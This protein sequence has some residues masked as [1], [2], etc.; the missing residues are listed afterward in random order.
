MSESTPPPQS[1]RALPLLVFLEQSGVGF[2]GD[3]QID[4]RSRIPQIDIIHGPRLKGAAG[5]HVADHGGYGQQPLSAHLLK[6]NQQLGG[7]KD[8][9]TSSNRT[10]ACN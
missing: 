7:W 4:G 5:G 3:G 9:T 8:T 2:L 1:S 10:C 6:L